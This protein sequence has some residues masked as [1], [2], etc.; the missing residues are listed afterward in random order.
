MLIKS[1]GT[2]QTGTTNITEDISL[3]RNFY[4]VNKPSKPLDKINDHCQGHEI[5]RRF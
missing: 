1:S 2:L 3:D 4:Y 5:W